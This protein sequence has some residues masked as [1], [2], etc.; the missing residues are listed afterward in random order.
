[1]ETSEADIATLAEQAFARGGPVI[2]VMLRVAYY[3][4]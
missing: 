4:R 1:M 3:G 2:A